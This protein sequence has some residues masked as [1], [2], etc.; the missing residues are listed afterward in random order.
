M[1]DSENKELSS[2]FLRALNNYREISIAGFAQDPTFDKMQETNTALIAEIYAIGLED[3][4]SEDLI[5]GK[6]LDI[7]NEVLSACKYEDMDLCSMLDAIKGVAKG[8]LPDNKNAQIL[9]DL[10]MKKYAECTEKEKRVIARS[11]EE[12]LEMVKGRITTDAG[13]KLEDE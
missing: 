12:F 6:I 4:L 8:K 11:D 3:G 1:T 13:V 7:S 10:I 2:R 9:F 5:R